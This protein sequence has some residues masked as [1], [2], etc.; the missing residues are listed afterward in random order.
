MDL[1]E[2][3][4]KFYY[5]DHLKQKEIAKIVGK[6]PSYISQVLS[7]TDKSKEKEQRHQQSLDRK[8]AYNNEYWQTYERPCHFSNTKEEY[9]AFRQSL[10]ND[11]RY[12]STK[13]EMSDTQLAYC[14]LSAYHIDKNGNL[15]LDKS[16]NATADMPKVINRNN[17]TLPTQ[18]Y[19]NILCMER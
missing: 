13:T 7:K 19:K 18:K 9:D 15:K 1:I 17:T 11:N 5:E 14:N 8:K 3:I 12:L 6:T 2:K 10:E 4:K 16:L